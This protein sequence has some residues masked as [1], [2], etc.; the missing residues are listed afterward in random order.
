MN[1]GLGRAL[2]A[3]VATPPSLLQIGQSTRGDGKDCGPLHK[4][5]RGRWRAAVLI[6]MYVLVAIHLAHW[7]VTGKTITPVEPSEAMQTLGDGLINAGFIF[8]A[9]TI[10]GTLIF[11]RFFCGWA[12]H[13]VSLQDLCTWLLRRLNIRPKPFRSRLLIFVPLL[14]ALHMFVWPSAYRFWMG[15]PLPR[16]ELHLMTDDFWRTFP[17]WGIAALTFVSCGFVIVYLLGNKGFCTYACPY[18]GIFGPVDYLAP[19]KIRVT[20]DCNGCGHCTATCTSNVRVHEEVARYGMVVN[21]G[22]MKCMDCID[23]CPNHAL[24]FG[25]GKPTAMGPKSLEKRPRRTFDFTWSE[26]IGMALVW[27]VVLLILVGPHEILLLALGWEPRPG[28]FSSLYTRCPLLMSLG[29]S[30]ICT[31]LVFTTVRL[32]YVP[33][34]RLN[35]L[36]L[37]R[38]GRVTVSGYAFL[39]VMA[40]LIAFLGHSAFLQYHTWRGNAYFAEAERL[41]ARAGRERNPETEAAVERSLAHLSLAERWGLIGVANVENK[42]G[43][44]YYYQDKADLCEQRLRR[45]LE[46]HPKHDDANSQLVDL[47]QR[48]DRRDDA[49]RHLGEWL[50]VDPGAREAPAR[51]VDQA[52]ARNDPAAARKA[53]ESSLGAKPLNVDARLAYGHLL[54]HTGDLPRALEQIREAV[55]QAPR[56]SRGYHHLGLLLAEGGR[57]RDAMAA[58]QRAV[59]LGPGL[60]EGRL[61]LAALALQAGETE[62]VSKQLSEVR[63]SRSLPQEFLAPWAQVEAPTARIDALIQEFSKTSSHDGAAT[64]ALTFLQAAKGDR[65][66]IAALL[67]PVVVRH[68]GP[69]PI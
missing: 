16:V 37:R 22:C 60:V 42:L 11:G 29:I 36:M 13:I 5:R 18:G 51:L 4:S 47:Y 43:S 57:I 48:Q 12:C 21:T 62:L 68:L 41:D 23:V 31:F 39:G 17:M 28:L 32:F 67:Q 40:L 64:Y 38:G 50:R 33:N 10:L 63:R 26:E 53:L 61:T 9:V 49:L 65:T 45:A 34:V 54:A 25:F 55:R 1:S 20:D 27:S 66:A 46:I 14:A 6:S 7:Y 69:A 19:G 58:E 24:Y 15:H 52:L 59:E 35:P 44:I 3:K 2:N 8:L 30:V 56:S